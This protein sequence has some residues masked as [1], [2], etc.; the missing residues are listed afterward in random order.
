[1]SQAI[2][3]F[4][5]AGWLRR[6]QPRLCIVMGGGLVT[7]W[8]QI[9]GL[10]NPFGGLLDEL[11]AGPGE[12]A[13]LN[14]C[15]PG[16]S[17]KAASQF[18]PE[19]LPLNH[20]LAPVPILPYSTSDGC[21][22]R[23]C[24]F[25]P[26][27]AEKRP[28]RP[29]PDDIVKEDLNRLGEEMQPGLIHFLDDALAPRLLAHLSDHP[30]G[31]P[32]YGF[33]RITDHL[34]DPDF[35]GGLRASGCVMLKLGIE[36]GHQGVLEALDKGTC[37]EQVARVLKVLSAVGISVY[38]Y[39]LFGTPAEDE[40]AARRTLEWTL[41]HSDAIDFLNLAIFNLPA[42]SPEAATLTTRNFYPG[43]L[44]LYADFE[45]PRGWHRHRVRR[46]LDTVF[47]KPA[48][49][50]RILAN[51]PPHFTS[52]HAPFVVMKRRIQG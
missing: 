37:I 21:W 23:K 26:E 16:H 13:L 41:A 34:A 25:C 28:Y 4:A 8:R 52:N 10:G 33:A 35:A 42:G 20:Y 49:I 24:A 12:A 46:F 9:P 5:I 38:A 40:A 32:W 36:S 27:T 22:W 1:M 19:A 11:I 44:S 6:H 2:C 51:D 43:D 48:P 47:K 15:A 45:H 18:A 39:L 7:S 17:P 30:P 3:A 31:I 29:L 14:L 50:R